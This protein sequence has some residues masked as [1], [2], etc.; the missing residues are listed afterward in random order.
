MISLKLK[1]RKKPVN[2]NRCA[3]ELDKR[4]AEIFDMFQLNPFIDDCI[5]TVGQGDVCQKVVE[6]LSHALETPSDVM[7]ALGEPRQ[8][9]VEKLYVADNLTILNVVWAPKMTLLPHNHNMWAIIGVYCGRENNIFWKRIQGDSSG[10][11]TTANAKTL[12]PGDVTLLGPEVIHSVTNPSDNFTG[13]IH[14]YGG[15]FFAQNRSEWDPESLIEQ[16]YDVEK[17]MNYFKEANRL[18]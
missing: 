8:G 18:L 12:G 15:D 4:S 10:K 14:I 6:L 13:A 9:G 3:L 2:L 7:L 17:N 16:A 5:S 11:I 1:H